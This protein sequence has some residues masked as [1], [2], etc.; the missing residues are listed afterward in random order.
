MK[1][2]YLICKECS[3]ENYVDPDCEIPKEMY[4]CDQCGAELFEK[5]EK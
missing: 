5:K 4:T 2:E 1:D 3:H